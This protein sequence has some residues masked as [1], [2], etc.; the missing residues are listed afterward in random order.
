MDNGNCVKHKVPRKKNGL[1]MLCES[2]WLNEMWEDVHLRNKNVLALVEGPPGDG[3]SYFSMNTAQEIDPTFTHETL[4]ERCLFHPRQFA[5]I[6]S[7]ERLRHGNALLMEE[8]GTQADH[9]KWFSFNNMLINY[10]LQTFR[11]QRLIAIFNVPIIDYI[12]SDSRKLFKYHVETL[13]IDKSNNMNVVKI[14][15]QV[16]NSATKKIYRKFLRYRVN[17]QWIRFRLWKTLKPPAKLCHAY[18]PLHKA[19]K[20]ELAEDLTKQMTLMEKS[21][22]SREDRQLLDYDGAIKRVLNER[23]VFTKIQGGKVVVDQSLVEHEFKVGR[24][25]GLRIKRGAELEMLRES[26]GRK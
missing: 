20:R 8:M 7:Q 4:K 16:Y 25:L 26:E 18:E 12:D 10:I 11:H 22:K 1:C 24:G 5:Q 21:D 13:G 14:K 23:E 9:R 6:V 3:K 2:P 19:F 15:K 17:G